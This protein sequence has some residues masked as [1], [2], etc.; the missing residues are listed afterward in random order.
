MKW[1]RAAS[2]AGPWE[3]SKL[4]LLPFWKV[5]LPHKEAGSSLLEDEAPGEREARLTGDTSIQMCA[6]ALLDC[7]AAGK[8][9]DNYSPMSNP[10]R[11]GLLDLV[12]KH[13]WHPVKFEIQIKKILSEYKSNPCNIW[14]PGGSDSKESTCSAGD[15]GLIPGLGR[16]PGG[17]HGNPLQCSCLENPMN[18]GA[19]RATV[20][21]VAK[22]RTWLSD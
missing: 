2:K 4:L 16:S 21:G 7:P 11:A 5:I 10:R 15:L 19:W 12:S 17:G 20:H 22:S 8:R 3:A 14:L 18:R 13:S 9:T 6:E 1:H